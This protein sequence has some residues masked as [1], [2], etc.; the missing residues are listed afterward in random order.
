M[1]AIRPVLDGDYLACQISAIS[2]AAS[3]FACDKN[4]RDRPIKSPSV[5]LA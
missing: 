5:L 4:R 3:K 1:N 2:V